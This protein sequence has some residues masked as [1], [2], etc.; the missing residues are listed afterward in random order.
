MRST[1]QDPLWQTLRDEIIRLSDKEELLTPYFH[2]FVLKHDSLVKALS[3][4]LA[5][6]LASP[7]VAAITLSKELERIFSHSEKVKAAIAKDLQAIAARD[8]AARGIA[9]PFLHYKGFHS[10]EAYRASHALWNEKRYPMAYYLH[11]RIAEV[12]GVDIHPAAKIGSGV[13]IDHAT[14][15]VIGETASVGD[16]VSM[17]H[18]VTLGG[19]GKEQ[20][21]RHPKVGNGVLIGAGAQILGNVAIGEGSKIGAGSVVLEP[22]PPHSTVAGVPARIVGHPK[23][24]RPALSMDQSIDSEEQVFSSF[25]ASML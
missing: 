10:L 25:T 15:V 3:A 16:D 14:G 23:T 7:Q 21:D 9:E 17:L 1:R 5:A 20:G 8:P 13:F 24:R 18:G 22:V 12:F 6:K 19:T 4:L 2:E 11:N